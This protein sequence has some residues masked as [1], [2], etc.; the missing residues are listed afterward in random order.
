MTSMAW[1]WLP[2]ETSW[3]MLENVGKRIQWQPVEAL[4]AAGVTRV[5]FE[6]PKEVGERCCF[7]GSNWFP[8]WS[9]KWSTKFQC[10]F[11]KTLNTFNHPIWELNH[12]EWPKIPLPWTYISGICPARWV[13]FP[14]SRAGGEPNASDPDVG[15]A[16]RSCPAN[17][18]ITRLCPPSARSMLAA[19]AA[20]MEWTAIPKDRERKEWI[21]WKTHPRP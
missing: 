14:G 12:F 8:I 3:K 13:P 20:G 4:I 11:C 17:D 2:P 15:K 9:A 7:L 18:E 6:C 16:G 1:V 21:R 10:F 19:Q 5:I